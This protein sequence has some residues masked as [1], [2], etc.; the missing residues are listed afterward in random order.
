[1]PALGLA[2]SS[3]PQDQSKL[4]QQGH[5]KPLLPI[6]GLRFLLSAADQPF[7][8]SKAQ[9]TMRSGRGKKDVV[10]QVKEVKTLVAQR[11]AC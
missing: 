3:I 5:S 9:S 1:M 8:R 2:L 6:D 10:E 11:Q 7:F 4:A